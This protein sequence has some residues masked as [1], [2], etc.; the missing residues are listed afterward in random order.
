MSAPVKVVDQAI[1]V[2]SSYRRPDL[3]ARLRRARA[4]LLDDQVRVLVVGEFRSRTQTTALPF[5]LSPWTCD[6]ASP[7]LRAR[8]AS[9]R[10][11]LAAA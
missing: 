6:S 2:I 10:Q 5:R 11:M 1:E 9:S 7:A 4:R 8:K 3:E